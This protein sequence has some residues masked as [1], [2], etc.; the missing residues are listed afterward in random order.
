MTR[1]DER[2]EAAIAF[3]RS[4]E[5]MTKNLGATPREIAHVRA[6]WSELMSDDPWFQGAIFAE[7]RRAAAREAARVYGTHY[8]ETRAAYDARLDALEA[9]ARAKGA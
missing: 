1:R 2:I 3:G 4:D 5:W 6:A 9:D 8:P 7:S